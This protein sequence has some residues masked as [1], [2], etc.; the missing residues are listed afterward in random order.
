MFLVVVFAMSVKTL[1]DTDILSF[2]IVVLVIGL[3]VSV[4]VV[5]IVAVVFDGV[6]AI[7]VV[8]VVTLFS[9]HFLVFCCSL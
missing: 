3:T 4:T 7:L 9:R 2:I 5:A 6:V 8:C 1:C